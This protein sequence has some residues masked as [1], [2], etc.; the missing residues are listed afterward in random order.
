VGEAWSVFMASGPE[1]SNADKPKPMF[2]V[3]MPGDV[4][5]N[6]LADFLITTKGPQPGAK[7]IVWNS[8]DPVSGPGSNAMWDVH[9]RIGGANGTDINPSNCPSG[10]GS[11][12]PA[13]QCSGAYMMMH[14]APTSSCYLE[15]VCGWT[16]D[17]DIDAKG[18]IN[19]YNGRGLLV[20][21]QGPVWMY[22]TGM[23]HNLYYQYNFRNAKNIMM[24]MLQAETPYFQPSTDTPWAPTDP[25]DPP[26]CTGDPRCQMALALYMVGSSSIF[27]YGSGFY[28]FFNTW[29]QDCQKTPG[30]PNCQLDMVNIQ[31]STKIYM[32]AL[33][34]YGSVN[35]LTQKE[36][37]SNASENPN[38]FC[39]T[40]AVNLNWF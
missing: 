22:G 29:S 28:S 26:F 18:Q 31:D 32:Y 11:T 4:G 17:H 2:V 16:A 40:M 13:S 10:N 39:S 23:E 33:S 5:V 38:T 9:F 30:G 19:V 1:F 36:R 12:A 27:N 24:G 34:T 14:L 15:N 37:Y 25:T 35:M 8:R 3:G 20:E 21:S 6:Q 7:L